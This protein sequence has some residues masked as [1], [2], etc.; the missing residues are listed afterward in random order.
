MSN[1]GILIIA[2]T[3]VAVLALL[4]FVNIRNKKDR[5]SLN[6]DASDLVEET[7]GDKERRKDHV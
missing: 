3:G 1:T 5:K 6:P 7:R 4:I 2:I